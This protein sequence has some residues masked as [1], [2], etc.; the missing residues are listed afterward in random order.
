MILDE[1][2]KL[3]ADYRGD[4]TSALL[5]V[6]DPQQN[7]AFKDHYFEVPVDLSKVIFI[8]TANVLDTIPEP[9]R[10]R[11]EILRVSGYTEEEKVHIASRHL[12]PR[13]LEE[14]GLTEADL[15]IPDETLHFIARHFTREA[16]VRS[17]E[18]ELASIARKVARKVA[19]TN[20][21]AGEVRPT[22]VIAINDLEEYLGSSRFESEMGN[23]DAQIGVTTGL[24][25]TPRGGE[26]L[27][28]ETARMPGK[29]GL[30]LT[31]QL[32]DVMK[33]SA[34]IAL[35][36]LRANGKEIGIANA[37]CEDHCN[38]HVHVPAGAIP[39]DGPSAGVALTVALASQLSG[40]PARHDIAMTGEVTLTGR[41]L[42]VGGIKEKVLAARQ[43]GITNLLLPERNRADVKEIPE[44]TRNELHFDFIS[45]V[46][47]A[48]DKVLLP[49]EIPSKRRAK[50][51]LNITT[52][53]E[54][55]I[56]KSE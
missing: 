36:F 19:E 55:D 53:A 54:Q 11:M 39:K 29:G 52:P 28:I 7:Y 38:L 12:L 6:L 13:Q 24:A 25:W 50:K 27:F 35:D 33:E 10:D 32:G 34:Q 49:A 56:D 31:G 51:A 1:V 42:P 30:T 14:N 46:R 37:D 9:L 43:A 4:P 2:D 45:D 44:E 47:D 3:G 5:E 16:G 23:K 20:S 18:R 21:E 40:R 41:V 26:I 48:F 17:L 15:Q 8:T 22:F